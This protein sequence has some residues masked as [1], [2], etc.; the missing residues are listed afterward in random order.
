MSRS[1]ASRPQFGA[2]DRVPRTIAVTKT[3]L[4]MAI[5]P[6]SAPGCGPDETSGVACDVEG[7]QQ[8][9]NCDGAAGVRRCFSGEWQA[10]DCAPTDATDARADDEAV[11]TDADDEAVPTD[12]A[13]ETV[14]DVLAETS[15]ECAQA[16]RFGQRCVGGECVDDANGCAGDVCWFDFRDVDDWEA[17][18]LSQK[19]PTD[20][21]GFGA[22]VFD[23]RHV[24]YAPFAAASG[25]TGIFH[26]Y[27]TQTVF[28]ATASWTLF[29]PSALLTTRSLFGAGFDG[30]FAYFVP[31]IGQGKA[32]RFDTTA[33]T[34]GASLAW[35]SFSLQGLSSDG[36]SGLV[37]VN[38]GVYLAPFAAATGGF[39]GRVQRFDV[40]GDFTASASWS[41]FDTAAQL[42]ARAVGF[43][44]VTSDGRFVYFVPGFTDA[45]PHGFAVRYDST[46][47][48]SL[49]PSWESYDLHSRSCVGCTAESVGFAGATF[50][51][52]YVYFAPGVSAA[53]TTAWVMRFDTTAA[54]FA[55]D[56]AWRGFEITSLNSLADASSTPTFDG[57]FVY[58]PPNSAAYNGQLMVAYDTR[59]PFE[60]ADSW[61]VFDLKRLPGSPSGFAGAVF[62]GGHVYLVPSDTTLALRFQARS[63]GALLPWQPGY[64]APR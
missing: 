57:R 54:S 36:Y 19:H 56:A 14:A 25:Y 3:L 43:N 33:A 15:A 63:P 31:Y 8:L 2:P 40:T 23:G 28:T 17:F 42:D 27:D 26:R 55:D 12:A 34:F 64:R 60:R 5:L 47:D 39:S 13:D 30:R 61:A 29:D 24:M 7:E 51:G 38:G 6:L 45:G 9:C 18:D 46:R 48:F 10:C 35:S 50:D 44:G 58:F 52:R 16:C 1:D 22:A 41:T 32:L 21:T 49:K 53:R 37:A 11:S 62:D 59:L 4:F 20:N